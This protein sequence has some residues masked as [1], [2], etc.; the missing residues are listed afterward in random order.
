MNERIILIFGKTGTGKSTLAKKIYE[1]E[2]RVVIIDALN[3]HTKNAKIFYNFLECYNFF[4]N[5]TPGDSFKISIQFDNDIDYDFLFKLL[6]EVKNLLLVLEEAEIYISPQVKSSSFL[7]LV[8]YGRHRKIKILGIARRTA[9]LSRDF[10]SQ[11]NKIISFKQTEDIDIKN[12]EA[13]GIT[14]LEKLEKFD[15][16]EKIL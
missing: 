3:E 15:F 11:T 8:R 13:L 14:G 6:F 9:E 2:K 12:M 1:T 4:I 7:R 16:V 10:R 5:V